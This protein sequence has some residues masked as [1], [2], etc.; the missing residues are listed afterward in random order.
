MRVLAPAKLNLHLR[1]SPIDQSGFH[2]LMS[3]MC[4]IALFDTLTI[5][6]ADT[7]HVSLTCDDSSL[8]CDNT[9]LVVRAAHAL[10][11]AVE[12]PHA[13]AERTRAAPD[14]VLLDEEKIRG[15]ASTLCP[16]VKVHLEKRIPTGGGLGG[17]SSDAART[18]L[19]LNRLWKLNW[20][21]ERLA[22]IAA[23]LGSDV[24]FFLYGS[25]SIC[26]ARGEVVRPI[27]APR[28]R[29]ALLI[30]PDFPMATPAVYRKFDEL[31]LGSREAVDSPAPV[32]GWTKLD[33]R[34]LLQEL[35]N[36][37]EAP[38]F[39]ICPQLGQLR[40]RFED[41]LGRPVRMSGSGSTLF[42]LFDEMPE[43]ELPAAHIGD[44]QRMKT[45]VVPIAPPI[46]DDLRGV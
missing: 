11:K 23:Q 18:L 41:D 39:E 24:P 6:P 42:T 28:P 35:V 34:E 9:N 31:R 25:S 45:A 33:A 37:L 4:T 40:E 7:T 22:P 8:P 10:A 5:E 27:T 32:D 17:G 36:D 44:R 12:H 15:D 19:A 46:A 2:P 1:V 38:A 14:S 26:T 20:D 3:W 16:G 43:A 13:G 29:A 30:L 21:T